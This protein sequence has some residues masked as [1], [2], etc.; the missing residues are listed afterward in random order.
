MEDRKHYSKRREDELYRV[1]HD[2]IMDVRIS[3]LRGE[4]DGISANPKEARFAKQ[5]SMLGDKVCAVYRKSY[6]K[7]KK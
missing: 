2:A 7:G 4:Y 3:I 5:T 1:V 6:A